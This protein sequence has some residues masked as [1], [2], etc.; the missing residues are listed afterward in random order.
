MT[1]E[2]SLSANP[3]VVATN[4]N[5]ATY[6]TITALSGSQ[7]MF[8]YYDGGGSD[9]LNAVV[10]NATSSSDGQLYLK[11]AGKP[12]V[13]LGSNLSPNK[14]EATTLDSGDV[15]VAYGDAIHNNGVT[16][17]LV[18]YNPLTGVI[19]FTSDIQITTG[20]TVSADPNSFPYVTSLT[21][22]TI[23]GGSQVVVMFV[24]LG[25]NGAIVSAVINVSSAGTV[26]H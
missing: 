3:L 16:C 19:L 26:L 4:K 17:T 13:Y 18:N 22:A 11:L 8:L 23:G 5:Y 1:L 24:D 6:F 20:S 7:A 21:I 15:V 12:T 10:L 9:Q 14:I 2:I 25:L